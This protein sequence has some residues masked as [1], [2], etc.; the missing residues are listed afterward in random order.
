MLRRRWSQLQGGVGEDV[1]RSSVVAPGEERHS[2]RAKIDAEE[3]MVLEA[4]PQDWEGSRTVVADRVGNEVKQ[5]SPD[6][7]PWSGLC[8][9]RNSD[10]AALLVQR[11]V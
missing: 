11:A 2:I 8:Y 9:G 4:P 1:R 3:S 7:G 10:R 6:A 5:G